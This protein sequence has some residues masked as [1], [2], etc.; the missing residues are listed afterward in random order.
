MIK[1]NKVGYYCHS[2]GET[3]PATHHCTCGT[4]FCTA[5]DSKVCPICKTDWPTAEELLCID[6]DQGL[7]PVGMSW[8]QLSFTQQCEYADRTRHYIANVG[9]ACCGQ[10]PW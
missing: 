4:T 3:V 9:N 10:L 2:C 6:I 5:C 7:V 8:E 1:L